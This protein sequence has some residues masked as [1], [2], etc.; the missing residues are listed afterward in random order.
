MSEWAPAGRQKRP[1]RYRR[2]AVQNGTQAGGQVFVE[3]QQRDK[4]VPTRNVGTGG[5]F[6]WQSK[7]VDQKPGSRF[8]QVRARRH[9]SRTE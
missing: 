6:V 9:V 1:R 5:R 3:V 7:K 4:A 2:T 8:E